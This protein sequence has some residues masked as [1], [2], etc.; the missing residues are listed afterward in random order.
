MGNWEKRWGRSS[1]KQW[2]SSDLKEGE[3]RAEKSFRVPKQ[4]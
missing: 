4:K 1:T 2:G 3:G